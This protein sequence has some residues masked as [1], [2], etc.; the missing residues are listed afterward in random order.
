MATYPTK[1]E[2][3]TALRRDGAFAE[4]RREETTANA[5][6]VS[7]PWLIAEVKMPLARIEPKGRVYGALE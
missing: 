4:G 2:T 6:R 7:L 1:T 3:T 5:R